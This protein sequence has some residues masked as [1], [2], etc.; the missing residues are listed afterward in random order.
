LNEIGGAGNSALIEGCLHMSQ[1]IEFTG[2]RFLPEISGQIAFEHLHR[3]HF[4]KGLVSGCRVLDVACGEGYGSWILSQSASE[5]TGVDI[6]PDAVAHARER[7]VAPNINFVEASAAKLPFEDGVFDVVVSFETIEH[8]DLHQEMM[9]EI[10]RVLRK[11]GTLIISS[12]NKQYYSIEPGYQNP[13]HVKELF[14]EEFVDLIKS[15]FAN[16]VL[17]SQ[18]VVHGSLMIMEG[19]KNR[20]D[21][22]SMTLSDTEFG[23]ARGLLKPLYDLL[24]ASDG[25]LPEVHS[26]IFEAEVHGLEPAR[27]Y[28]IHLPDRVAKADAT[29]L[30]LQQVAKD[31]GLSE[32]EARKLFDSLSSRIEAFRAEGKALAERLANKLAENDSRIDHLYHAT[33][34]L[35]ADQHN[36]EAYRQKLEAAEQA[37]VAMRNSLSWRVTS[38]LRRLKSAWFRFGHRK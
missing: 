19:D 18:R 23:S 1:N 10:K 33:D 22:D 12:P 30:E 7:Y 24:V 34:D 3:Y 8:H 15:Y 31:R 32:D 4:A 25:A 35:L 2:E 14:R 17:F 29:I 27:F 13:F 28:G 36:L 5:V 21:F 37:L 9:S 26:S 20:G 16:A 6:A 38:P 11:D